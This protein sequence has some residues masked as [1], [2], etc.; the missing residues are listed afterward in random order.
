MS[1]AIYDAIGDFYKWQQMPKNGND[2]F[3]GFAGCTREALESALIAMRDRYG[4]EW[5][6]ATADARS[7]YI[8]RVALDI[9]AKTGAD[10]NGINKFLYW[11]AVAAKGRQDVMSWFNGGEFTAVDYYVNL[12]K[13]TISDKASSAVE[14]IKY[15]VE[16]ESP[17]QKTFFSAILPVAAILGTCYVVKKVLD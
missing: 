9:S 4:S 7:G 5:I 2:V 12:I 11:A 1:L 13:D 3:F 10:Y 15:G 6:G 16:K 14:T 8:G 17:A